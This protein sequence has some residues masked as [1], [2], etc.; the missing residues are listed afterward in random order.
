M[1]PTNWVEDGQEQEE[2]AENDVSCDDDGEVEN[3]DGVIGAAIDHVVPEDEDAD[4]DEVLAERSDLLGE[5]T[6]IESS[7]IAEV[8]EWLEES[9]FGSSATQL[10]VLTGK[11][12][13]K[14]SLSELVK[15]SPA[16]GEAIHAEL[17]GEGALEKMGHMVDGPC[18][19]LPE[20]VLDGPAEQRG[21][22]YFK[23]NGMER[24]KQ[25][26]VGLLFNGFM[27]SGDRL[28]NIKNMDAKECSALAPPP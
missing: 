4:A 1:C 2:E 6:I 27:T 16:R 11:Q 20:K 18:D 17:H 14:M 22:D 24:H 10:G 15:V 8:K 5:G 28:E 26:W 21:C 7:T 13:L 19:T 25:Y 23:L 3:D 12:L 9:G